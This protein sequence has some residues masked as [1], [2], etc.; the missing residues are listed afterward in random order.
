MSGFTDSTQLPG[1]MSTDSSPKTYHPFLTRKLNAPMSK[2]VHT[3]SLLADY[4]AR[5]GY[6]K[7]RSEPFRDA[8]TV[9]QQYDLK[10]DG[11]IVAQLI[12]ESKEFSVLYSSYASQSDE[13]SFCEGP[14]IKT[15]EFG[16][17]E[18]LTLRG[19]LEANC[20]T[21]DDKCQNQGCSNSIYEHTRK[22]CHSR[23]CI[24]VTQ[25]Q[26]KSYAKLAANNI[27]TWT[28]CERCKNTSPYV[29]LSEESWNMSFGKFLQLRIYAHEYLKPPCCRN[30][31]A[32]HEHLFLDNTWYFAYKNLVAVF[33]FKAIE[34]LAI[35]LP[36]PSIIW[37]DPKKS[38]DMNR[39]PEDL[40]EIT[41]S[42]GSARFSSCYF[43]EQFKKLRE[44]VIKCEGD[45]LFGSEGVFVTSLA[46]CVPWEAKGGKSGST[47]RKTADDRFILKEISSIEFESFKNIAEFYFEY[48]EKAIRESKKSV[49]AKILGMYKVKSTLTNSTTQ[50]SV[51]ILVME[52]LFYQRSI[53]QKFDLKGSVRNRLAATSSDDEVVLLD[54]N[55]I[56]MIREAPFY[57]KP[58]EKRI[59]QA[60]IRR[61]SSFL[62]SHELVD[63]SLLVGKDEE[64]NQLVVGIIDYIRSFTWHKKVETFVKSIPTKEKPT[65][66]KPETYRDRFI[67]KMDQYFL[68]VPDS[69]SPLEVESVM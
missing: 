12:K 59:L 14:L 15:W 30:P 21:N 33:F 20:F 34:V 18:D 53:K 39:L 65:I 37:Q 1:S 19:F 42:D 57:V 10:A 16:T 25:K 58:S 51:Y 48:M 52:N 46:N 8:E 26:L 68:A 50:K 23:G 17:P 64:Q 36:S 22:F 66:V 38:V 13:A 54:E 32:C 24:K 63:Y 47:F 55:L 44:L 41:F 6:T 5:G 61:D 27:I 62:A 60:A 56:R 31:D 7:K 28:W 4:R 11:A 69:S 43:S 9:K 35:S 49:L 45:N 40:E 2:S 3:V 29:S 67:E